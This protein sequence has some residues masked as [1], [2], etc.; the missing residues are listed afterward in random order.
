MVSRK[1]GLNERL[2]GPPFPDLI[3]FLLQQTSWCVCVCVCVYVCFRVYILYIYICD[4]QRVKRSA[5][6]FLVFLGNNATLLWFVRFFVV[7]SLTPHPHL[8]SSLL[9]FD[10][11]S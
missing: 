5:P 3:Y 4:D 9:G 11:S 2:S 10:P 7:L 1:S 6:T 8:M